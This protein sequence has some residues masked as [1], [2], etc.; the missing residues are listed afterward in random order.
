MC[1][2][3]WTSGD[4]MPIIYFVVFALSSLLPDSFPRFSGTKY[5]VILGRIYNIPVL[6]GSIIATAFPVRIPKETLI[7][8][9]WY[10]GTM[11]HYLVLLL[12]RFFIPPGPFLSGIFFPFLFLFVNFVSTKGG[13]LSQLVKLNSPEKIANS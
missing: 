2:P 3:C 5:G 7:I 11:H 6:A 13:V 4:D 9:C 10:L 8:S 12:Y 1:V